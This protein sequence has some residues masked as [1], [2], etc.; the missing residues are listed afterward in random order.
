VC[1]ALIRLAVVRLAVVRTEMVC[2]S[3]NCGN[4]ITFQLV[5]MAQH[6]NFLF[7]I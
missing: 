3:T 1:L 7:L 4:E 5:N 2:E 6:L